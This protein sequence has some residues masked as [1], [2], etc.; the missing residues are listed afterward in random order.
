M[1]EII[2]TPMPDRGESEARTCHA[3]S[4]PTLNEELAS[5]L[6][7]A[8]RVVA[9]N[10]G[11]CCMPKPSTW[12]RDCP[13]TSSITLLRRSYSLPHACV[14]GTPRWPLSE[15]HRAWWRGEVSP[16]SL[17]LCIFYAFSSLSCGPVVSTAAGGQKVPQL[18]APKALL[19][20]A[21]NLVAHERGGWQPPGRTGIEPSKFFRSTRPKG[22]RGA[23]V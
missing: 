18:R 8:D 23:A 7:L 19:A 9:Q 3:A 22:A 20:I 16:N 13:G 11:D 6:P 17:N 15:C 1:A 4:E 5:L 21:P 2:A 12:V 10:T 14:A